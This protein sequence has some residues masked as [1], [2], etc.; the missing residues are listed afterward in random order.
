MPSII[1]TASL[2]FAEQTDLFILTFSGN[3]GESVTLSLE[4]LDNTYCTVANTDL[5]PTEGKSITAYASSKTNEGKKAVITLVL[6]KV[7]DFS[8]SSGSGYN[9]SGVEVR[10]TS[11]QTS[12]YT[13][14]TI[15]NNTLVSKGGHR[16]NETIPTFTVENT[17]LKND[18]YTVEISGLGYVPYKATGVTFENA[19]K[20]TN[21]DFIPGD[22]NADGEVDAAD[23]AECEK[24]VADSSYASELGE[25]SDFNR[26][27]VTDKYDLVIFGSSST[28]SD[29]EDNSGNNDND[30][31]SDANPPDNDNGSDGSTDSGSGGSDG[32]SGGGGGG[33]GGGSSTQDTSKDSDESEDKQDTEETQNSDNSDETSV[34]DIFT[35]LESYSWAK[36]YIY[37]LKD[38]GIIS[39]ISE[40]EYAPA[41]NIK[42]GDFILILTRML[43]VNDAFTENFED[44]SKDSYYYNAIGSAKAIGIASGDGQ[45]FMPE[46]TITRQDLITLAYRAFLTKGYIAETNDMASLD[47]FDDKQS[48]SDYA[49][50]AMASM[51]SAGI[52]KGSDGSVN[53]LGFA[54]RA[55]VAVMCARLVGLMN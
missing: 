26:D 38:K 45:N 44:V 54:T 36:E 21:K 19:L 2:S 49:Q 48:I 51:V 9:T 34:Q 17:V 46:N 35:D 42:R 47:A 33:G 12:G 29:D 50:T 37:F 30:S 4:D 3:V 53:P 20:L 18:T 13:I 23:K 24:A 43:G 15:L 39:G 22:I 41:N 16:E 5:K 28:D 31:S 11:E 7:T 6:D 55:E 25:A 10:L 1:S 14:Y 8:A 52:I 40:T 32:G 27:G